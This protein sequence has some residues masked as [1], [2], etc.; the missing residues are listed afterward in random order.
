MATYNKAALKDIQTKHH[1]LTYKKHHAKKMKTQELEALAETR[2][3]LYAVSFALF[4]RWRTKDLCFPVLYIDDITLQVEGN[5]YT[6]TADGE[7]YHFN[8]NDNDFWF[9]KS[10][11]SAY[12]RKAA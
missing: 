4:K 11:P 5:E 1:K 3:I 10:D 12:V 7:T 9:W 8:E 6:V 2:R